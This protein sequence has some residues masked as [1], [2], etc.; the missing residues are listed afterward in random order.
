MARRIEEFQ[1]AKHEAQE[2]FNI[3]VN[4]LEK[5]LQEALDGG[6]KEFSFD[7][8]TGAPVERWK[9]K[10]FDL[11][12][13]LEKRHGVFVEVAGPT[14]T[15]YEQVD[16]NLDR[17]LYISNIVQGGH[18]HADSTPDEKIIIPSE[19]KIDFQ[20]DAT[21]L[22]LA[23]ESVGALFASCLWKFMRKDSIKEASRVIEDSGLFVFQRCLEG[24]IKT[25]KKFGFELR[26]YT[27]LE[28][29]PDDDHPEGVD[30]FNVVLQKLKA[31][32]K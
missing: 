3:D 23:D 12:H 13:E 7:E 32:E 31:K 1:E 19:S 5:K 8:T 21:R 22:P 29:P 26:Q 25:A 6:K 4:E 28:F 17:K 24:D 15:G 18:L 10:D 20:A 16:F 30:M 14:D 9:Q 11:K 27:K 2:G